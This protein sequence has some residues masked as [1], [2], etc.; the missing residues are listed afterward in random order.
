MAKI[1]ALSTGWIVACWRKA[2]DVENLL[3]MKSDLGKRVIYRYMLVTPHTPF[4]NHV[5]MKSWWFTHCQAW[6]EY[7][8]LWFSAQQTDFNFIF[9]FFTMKN[10]KYEIRSFRTCT[11]LRLGKT[12]VQFASTVHRR[13]LSF[14]TSGILTDVEDASHGY[15][16]HTWMQMVSVSAEFILFPVL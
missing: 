9:V 7:L 12:S 2:F 15:I 5:S 10:S 8:L 13:S 14:F 11:S 6:G 3:S 1:V 16:A 4:G